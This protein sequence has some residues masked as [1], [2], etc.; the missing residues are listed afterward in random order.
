MSAGKALQVAADVLGLEVRAGVHVGEVEM[1]A[2][3]VHGQAVVAASRLCDAA[4]AGEVLMSRT[5]ADLLAGSDVHAG[6][7]RTVL[8]KGLGE[9]DAHIG[10]A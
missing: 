9:F 10:D 5:A 2:F 4:A 6:E 3:D 1:A 7:H 8:L